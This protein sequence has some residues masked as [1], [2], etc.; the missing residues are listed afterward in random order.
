MLLSII[1]GVQIFQRITYMDNDI[2]L[3]FIKRRFP[4]DSHWLD[5]NCFYFAVILKAR[6]P[7]GKI[8]YDTINGHF[9]VDIA[10]TNYDWNGVVQKDGSHNYIEWDKFEQYDC[11]QKERIKRDCL[12]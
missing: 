2:V 3:D 4:E 12:M 11:I 9:V 1:C 8:L 5:G 10:G 6:F 7:V